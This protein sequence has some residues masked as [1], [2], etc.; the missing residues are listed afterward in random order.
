MSWM[1]GRFLGDPRA[2][3][4]CLRYH[5]WSIGDARDLTFEMLVVF[6]NIFGAECEKLAK[7]HTKK[8]DIGRFLEVQK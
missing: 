3:F 8:Y 4:L 2:Y 6:G 7:C 5:F 1:I